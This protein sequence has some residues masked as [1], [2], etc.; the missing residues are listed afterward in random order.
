MKRSV[1][2]YAFLICVCLVL[3]L[4]TWTAVAQESTPPTGYT[5][6]YSAVDLSN[7]RSDLDG[8][9]IL[10]NDIEFSASDFEEGGHFYNG[11]AGFA[12]IG[13]AEAPFIGTL[14][15]NGYVIDGLTIRFSAREAIY[16]GLFGYTAGAT[17]KNVALE[18]TSVLGSTTK[19]LNSNAP[20]VGSLVGYATDTKLVACHNSGA[21]CGEVIYP[22]SGSSGVSTSVHVGGLI[23]VAAGETVIQE[24]YNDGEVFAFT[25]VTGG[26][27]ADVIGYAGGLVGRNMGVKF[28]IIDSYNNAQVSTDIR[29]NFT[30]MAYSGGIC[31]QFYGTL[32]NVYNTGEVLPDAYTYD[33]VCGALVGSMSGTAQNCYYLDD[34]VSGF[35]ESASGVAKPIACTQEQMKDSATF[36][37]FDFAAVWMIDANNAQYALPQLR[38]NPMCAPPQTLVEIYLSVLP[39]K[40]SY[41]EAHDELD[42]TGGKLMLVYNDG[43]TLEIDLLPEMVSGFDAQKVGEQTLM[44]RYAECS[45]TYAVEVYAAVPG[46]LNGD[47]SIG[48]QDLTL[49]AQFLAGWGEMGTIS[50]LRDLNGDGYV[51]VEDL[52]L[53]AQKLSGWN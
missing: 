38:N 20:R 49:M 9:Y 41:L 16:V 34:G 26:R 17:L 44:I 40:L 37:G 43:Q 4:A 25:D 11:G 28:Q 27:S 46:D 32:S 21:V 42:V 24:C 31:G 47:G 15:G 3:P 36:D 23:G 33:Y 52:T 29:S 13:T 48:V 35:G 50:D 8:K 51:L 12:P 30:S 1:R 18:N 6:I 14:D 10:M 22:P 2:F 45:A 7:I 19:P 5:P 39:Q 53:L